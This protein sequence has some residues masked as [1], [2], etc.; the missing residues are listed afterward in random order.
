MFQIETHMI[1]GDHLPFFF[2]SNF[3]FEHPRQT[4]DS[5]GNEWA[6]GETHIVE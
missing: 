2:F 5:D 3:P 6:M 1:L 4:E